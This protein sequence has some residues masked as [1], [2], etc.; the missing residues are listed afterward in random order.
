MSDKKFSILL[1]EILFQGYFRVDRLHIQHD[2]FDGTPSAV[3]TREMYHRSP[4]VAG[5]LLF[6]PQH[7]KVVL[8]E[9]FRPAPADML[10]LGNQG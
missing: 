9:Q 3:F 10:S 4:L 6:D 1:R 2:R 5:I 7:D 8:V